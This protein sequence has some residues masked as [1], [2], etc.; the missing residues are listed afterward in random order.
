M[1]YLAIKDVWTRLQ[2]WRHK[3]NFSGSR[4]E[5]TAPGATNDDENWKLETNKHCL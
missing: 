4:G 2:Y 5:L 3:K 1:I